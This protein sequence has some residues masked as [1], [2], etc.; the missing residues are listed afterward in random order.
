MEQDQELLFLL[1]GVEVK[2]QVILL[3]QKYG[4]AQLGLNQET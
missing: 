2:L 3:K 4:M 1:G